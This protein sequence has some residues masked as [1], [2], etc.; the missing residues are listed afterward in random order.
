MIVKNGYVYCMDVKVQIWGS[1]KDLHWSY[2]STR[3]WPLTGK[4]WSTG[5]KK[6]GKKEQNMHQ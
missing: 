2:A 4:Q 3:D 5:E 6:N 1:A